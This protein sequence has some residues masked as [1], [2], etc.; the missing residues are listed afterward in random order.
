[1]KSSETRQSQHQ[2]VKP[3]QGCRRPIHGRQC[4]C[5]SVLQTGLIYGVSCYWKS[6][7]G[8]RNEP[9]GSLLLYIAPLT[10]AGIPCSFSDMK[11]IIV[12]LPANLT[13]AK[14]RT[15]RAS[16]DCPDAAKSIRCFNESAIP[17]GMQAVTLQHCCW[18][19]LESSIRRTLGNLPLLLPASF[20][21][22]QKGTAYSRCI[23]FQVFVKS[24]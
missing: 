13:S 9:S 2:F 11:P 23:T 6:C 8:C 21:V 18:P 4:L 3:L 17:C 7:K 5:G 10:H 1:M 22:P 16:G 15:G 24:E 12:Q 14:M 20:H 19:C